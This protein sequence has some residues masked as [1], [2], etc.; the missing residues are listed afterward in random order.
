VEDPIKGCEEGGGVK[1][2]LV[3]QKIEL[4][5]KEWLTERNRRRRVILTSNEGV[6]HDDSYI[7]RFN[8][9]CSFFLNNLFVVIKFKLV[10][11]YKYKTYN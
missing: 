7:Q 6:E 4:V 9:L 1:R 2:D 8:V 11:D 5:G 3:Q 10:V